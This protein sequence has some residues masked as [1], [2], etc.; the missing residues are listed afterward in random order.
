MNIK[1]VHQISVLM[2][3]L[4]LTACNLSDQPLGT[5]AAETEPLATATPLPTETPTSTAT[6][7]ATPTQTPTPTSTA[8]LTP[9]ST[10]TVTMTPTPGVLRGKVTI[11]QM[12][13]RYGP[14]TMYLFKY[15]VFQEQIYEII[16]RMEYSSWILIQASRGQNP[17]WVNSKYIEI[18]GDINYVS[19]VDPHIVLAWSPYYDALTAVSAQRNGG[20]VTVFWNLLELRA[21]DSSE[22]VPYVV[23]AWVCQLGLP[24]RGVC[25]CPGGILHLGRGSRGRTGL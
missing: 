13:C 8:T 11:E 21:G 12:A 9:T 4:I 25:L 17:C 5:D 24:G 20:V 15:S 7:T 18:R 16:G 6:Q 1:I 3:A 22:Q 14:G 10:P 2:L 19:Y 23:E